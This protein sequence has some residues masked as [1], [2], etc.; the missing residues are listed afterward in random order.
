MTKVTEKKN[1]GTILRKYLSKY[2]NVTKKEK[3]PND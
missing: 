3:I 2:E 1:N